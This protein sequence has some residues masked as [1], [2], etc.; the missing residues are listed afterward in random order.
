MLLMMWSAALPP[1]NNPFMD[2]HLAYALVLVPLALVGA[3]T[4]FGLAKQWERIPFVQKH[5]WLK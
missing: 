2:D 4:T 1:A 5:G 3:G